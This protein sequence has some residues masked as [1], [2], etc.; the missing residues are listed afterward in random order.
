MD[1]CGE[2]RT[3]NQEPPGRRFQSLSTLS[4]S[5]SA[6]TVRGSH[7]SHY[8]SRSL[9]SDWQSASSRS[10]VSRI[11]RFS[12]TFSLPVSSASTLRSRRLSSGV[13]F[14]GSCLDFFVMRRNVRA[15]Y[16]EPTLTA[17]QG[18][19][20]IGISGSEVSLRLFERFFF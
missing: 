9:A 11:S 15:T 1:S 19:G 2:T 8:S 7:N 6:G 17:C 18:C 13:N 3:R 20:F 10:G 12:S 4:H 5:P 14:S 16:K